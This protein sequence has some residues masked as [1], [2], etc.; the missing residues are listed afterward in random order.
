MNKATV[1]FTRNIRIALLASFFLMP[2]ASARAQSK[3]SF[4][5]NGDGV[6]DVVTFKLKMQA[7]VSIS[8]WLFEIKNSAGEL[9]KSFS[10][11]GRPPDELEWNG[12]DANNRLVVDG[13]YMFS[14]GVVTPAGNQMAIAP[15]PVEV[16]R[17]DPQAEISVDQTIFSPNGDGVKDEAQFNIKAFDAN[18]LHSWMLVLKDKNGDAV[19][20]IHGKGAP[21]PA[22]K[23]DGRGDFEEDV[24]DGVYTFVLTVHDLAGNKISTPPQSVTINRAGQISTVQVTPILFSP[25][26]DG[27]KDDVTFR[28]LS[29]GPELVD[30]WAFNIL[31]RSGKIVHTFSGVKEP[32]AKIVW[33]GMLA[34]KKAAPDGLYQVVLLETDRAGNTATTVPQTFEIDTIAPVVE[35]RLEPNLLSPNGD[36]VKDEGVFQLKA[37]D[38]QPLE[39]W[40]LKIT[41]DVGRTVKTI[42]GQP[43]S[44]PPATVAWRGDGADGKTLT[45][46]TYNYY[47]E[48]MDIGGNKASTRPQQLKI[49]C[50]PPV[51][52]VSADLGLFSPNGDGIMDEANFSLSVQD[53]S[54]LEFWKLVVSDSG[55]KQVRVFTGPAGSVATKI[56]WDGKNDDRAPLPDGDYFYVLSARDVAGNSSATAP[57][58]I[59]IGTTRPSP[60]VASDLRAIS[61]NSDGFK[62][63]AMFSLQV[64][65]FN[66]I[67]DW[68]LRISDSSKTPKRVYQGRGDVPGSLQWGGEQDDKKPL[69]DAE[70]TYSL[71]VVDEAGNRVA[72]APREI[73]IDTTRPQTAVQASPALFSPNGDKLKDETVFIPSYKDAS[74]IADWKLLVQDPA[75]KTVKT[76]S[77]K[78]ELPLSLAWDGKKDDGQL[79]P[80]GGYNYIFSAE[81]EVGNKSSTLEQIVKIDNTA[82]QVSL[83]AEPAL[84]SPNG[85]GV[86]DETM[87]FLDVKDASD[88]SSWKLSLQGKEPTASRTFSGIGRPPASFPWDGKND[89]GGALP[90]GGYASVLSAVDEVGNTGQNQPLNI[91]VDTS[92]PLITVTAETDS[93]D[94]LV[95]QMQVR[96]VEDKS[97]IISLS[98]EILFDTGQGVIKA[99]AYPTLMKAVNLIRRYPQRMV[100][101]EGHA[102]N[103]PIHNEQFAGNKELSLG[104]ARAVM[105]FFSEKGN[106]EKTRMSAYGFGDSKPKA[107]NAN[108]EGRRQN[109]RVEIILLKEGTKLD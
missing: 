99:P 51:L 5:P 33:D 26:G 65:A 7:D 82:P 106:I 55:N 43:G 83:Q 86:K 59:V 19:R 97:I 66:R 8:S 87:L 102:D 108:E 23:W 37:D 62:D 81:D 78:T 21:S 6:K 54:Q 69:P 85:D 41:N 70:Y 2:A 73:R 105:N 58:K 24:P 38:A 91:T 93:L 12:K 89:R 84:F 92:K 22:T 80:D 68:A 13:I 15:S 63:S 50:A 49:D 100:R 27:Y 74:P 45:D 31:N 44:K 61:P 4:S 79:L 29:G 35:A 28:I 76:F 18:G 60:Q 90:D 104:R 103:V 42:T 48:A 72:T 95:P 32:P 25:N 75:K 3:L 109:R 67:K 98:S 56:A 10:G 57:Q 46:G 94:E 88:I 40:A 17:V 47:I 77:G 1:K 34:S 107:S 96:Q 39:S 71:E 9:V 52:S 20:S 14:L 101:V 64:K 36:G 11:K 16:D 53:A 30:H